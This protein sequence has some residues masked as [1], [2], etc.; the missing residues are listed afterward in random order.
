MNLFFPE[1]PFRIIFFLGKAS[2]VI[3][4]YAGHVR[5]S[6]GDVRQR[7]QTFC[8]AG[9]STG[10]MSDR[11]DKNCRNFDMSK[12]PVISRTEIGISLEN[13]DYILEPDIFIFICIKHNRSICRS[14]AGKDVRQGLQ[15]SGRTLKACRTFCPAGQK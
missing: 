12:I 15:M 9:F 4:K 6:S 2:P 10:K 8:P 1:N 5:Q 11:E 14:S 3:V 7:A 13:K